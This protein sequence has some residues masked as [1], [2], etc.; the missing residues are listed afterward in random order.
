MSCGYNKIQRYLLL[1]ADVTIDEI[2]RLSLSSVI[3]YAAILTGNT[4]F[5]LSISINSRVN[6]RF[7]AHVLK[8]QMARSA[9][10]KNCGKAIKMA[11][12]GL[13]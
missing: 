12:V 2:L 4:F 1:P 11:A 10:N 8:Q 6:F 3:F 9:R 5:F 7:L 13:L